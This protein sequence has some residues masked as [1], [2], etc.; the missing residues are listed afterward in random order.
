[1]IRTRDVFI[2]CCILFV[3]SVGML[4]TVLVNKESFSETAEILLS[5]DNNEVDFTATNTR[6]EKNRQD[7]I[8]RLRSLIAKGETTITPSP[9]VEAPS[10]PEEN[11]ATSTGEQQGSLLSCG[12]DDTLVAKTS[13]PSGVQLS[14]K[15]G[16]RIASIS[17][18]LPQA[19][20]ASSSTSTVE[21][22]QKVLFATRAF[23]VK[24]STTK[25]VPGSI[26]GLTLSGGLIEND[27]SYF[28]EYGSESLVGYARDGFPIYGFYEG[29][30]DSCGGYQHTNGYRY[31]LTKGRDTVLNCFSSTPA[32]FVL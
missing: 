18:T 23:P 7:T 14:V 25:C 20:T 16:E 30:V 32:P 26:V 10:A 24:E 27:A 22:I 5:Q 6:I 15:N 2:F 31:T 9:S 11:R 17:V 13:W 4:I 12:G 1:M 3:I 19:S 8:A 21:T 29:E 28:G